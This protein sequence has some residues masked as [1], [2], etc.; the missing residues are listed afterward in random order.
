VQ[1]LTGTLSPHRAA[2]IYTL[3]THYDS[4][5][6]RKRKITTIELF[7]ELVPFFLLGETESVYGLAE[8]ILFKEKPAKANIPYLQMI[9]NN[10]LRNNDWWS[11]GG[12]LIPWVFANGSPWR[13]LLDY[14]VTM[15]IENKALYL[16]ENPDC[17]EMRML[18]KLQIQSFL[19]DSNIS[20]TTQDKQ[21]E[22]EQQPQQQSKK[23]NTYI[24]QKPPKEEIETTEDI[25]ALKAKL[26]EHEEAVRIA[27]NDPLIDNK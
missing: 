22:A 25:E 2:L 4:S 15:A 3:K 6:H 20:N 19:S 16:Y 14:D 23:Q 9:F 7:S 24:R 12:A 11:G 10:A 8:Y 13:S 17:E 21:P 26:I 27:E 1:N 18:T 5:L